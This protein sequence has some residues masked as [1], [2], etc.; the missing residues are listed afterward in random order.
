MAQQPVV[1]GWEA[2]P[3]IKPSGRSQV[4]DFFAE[5]LAEHFKDH[6]ELIE[7][8]IPRLEEDGPHRV[9]PPVWEG[10]SDGLFEMR[11]HRVRIYCSVETGQKIVMYLGRIKRWPKFEGADR[12]LA[13][14]ARADY[15]SG[16]YD[17]DER[18]RLY[19]ELQK[20]RGQP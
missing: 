3:Y 10:L 12:K 15:C 19:L 13:N 6:L 14:A 2:I 18:S 20:R 5:L 4:L 9:G 11:V 8:V 7:V 16:S 17:Q 1:S